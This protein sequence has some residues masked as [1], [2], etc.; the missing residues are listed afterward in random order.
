MYKISVIIPTFNS[1]KFLD[2]TIESVIKQTIGFNNIELILID[3]FS[4][5]KTPNIIEKYEKKYNNI[6][7]YN[8]KE[9][10]GSPG[11]ARNIGI[12]KAQSE[13]LMFMDHDD[14]YPEDALEILYNKINGEE[15]SL[16]IGRYKTFGVANWVSDEW[17]KNEI[18]INS[19][20]ENT[21]FITINNIWR[22]IFPKKLIQKNYIY[23]P[24]KMFAED[25][26]FMIECYL[27]VNKITFLP[28]YVYCF[29]IRSNDNSSTSYSKSAH[30]IGKLTDGYFYTRNILK[31]NHACKYYDLLFSMHLGSWIENIIHSSLSNKEKYELLKKAQPL[32]IDLNYIDLRINPNFEVFRIVME[33]LRD[34]NLEGAFNDLKIIVEKMNNPKIMKI[35]LTKKLK[36]KIKKFLKK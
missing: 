18:T 25:L 24:K 34:N 8:L 35:T 2:E 5:D 31:K 26:A 15:D 6:I 13:Y 1:E 20:D 17:V 36:N 32:F 10:A 23:F 3:D 11:T 33:E 4:T 22:M 29:R 27:N 14:L 30:Y 12:D 7:S 28:D 21:N 19:L 16:V 9:K